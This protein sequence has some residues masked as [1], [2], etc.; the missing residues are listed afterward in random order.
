MGILALSSAKSSVSV[1]SLVYCSPVRMENDP[2]CWGCYP[3]TRVLS[4]SLSSSR[5]GL[6]ANGV[7]EGHSMVLRRCPQEISILAIGEED[8]EEKRREGARNNK[9]IQ[10]RM[11]EHLRGR[12]GEGERGGDRL[13]TGQDDAFKG[14]RRSEDGKQQS[15]KGGGQ[16]AKRERERGQKSPP[17]T[18]P[19]NWTFGTKAGRQGGREPK[20][21]M[22]NGYS[23]LPVCHP[24]RPP[25]PPSQPAI[26][27]MVN[28]R[29]GAGGD[30]NGA[31]YLW[32]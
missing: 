24:P 19:A 32:L 28:N 25:R 9:A 17:P 7:T 11:G 12:E 14:R 26:R 31:A 13:S 22:R 8:G 20:N 3:L 10:L 15:A 21:G 4:L 2:D 18:Q 6:G 1:S 23:Q 5:F 29:R 27:D 16:E 30:K